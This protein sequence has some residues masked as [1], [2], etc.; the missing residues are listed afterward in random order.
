VD[1]EIGAVHLDKRLAQIAQGG[2]GGGSHVLLGHQDP[3]GS[4]VRVDHLAVADLVVH[5]AKGMHAKIIVADAK[6]RLLRYLGLG[7]QVA[8]GRIPS[9]KLD[10][11]CLADDAAPSVAADEVLRPQRLVV[12]QPDIDAAV[13]L[14]EVRHLRSVIDLHRQLGDPGG[15]DPLDLVLPDSERIRVTRREVAHVQHGR[16]Q[17][18][19]LSY[20]ALREEAIG[21]PTL[22]Q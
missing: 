13:V 17:H 19:G 11:G 15:H 22:V 20:L 8:P 3:Y 21:N 16:G 12:R 10:A 7:D 6:F 5:P 1:P 18:R 14:R 4:L 2:F 9:G